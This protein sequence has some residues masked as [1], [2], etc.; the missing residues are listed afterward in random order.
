MRKVFPWLVLALWIASAGLLAGGRPAAGSEAQNEAGLLLQLDRDFSRAAEERGAEGWASFFAENGSMVDKSGP[1]VT[2]PEAI[3]RHMAP[4]LDDPGSSLR[5]EPTLAHI[6][7]PGDLGYTLGRYTLKTKD[8]QE[9]PVV[10]TGAY[11]TLWRK[12]PDGSWKVLL[13][14][15]NEDPA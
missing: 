8:A 15:G 1:P 14:T 5:W 4:L 10:H 13:D 6:V 11:F 3:R 9:N 7:L 12:Q 2:G